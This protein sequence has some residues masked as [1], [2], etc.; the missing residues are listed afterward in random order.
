M[1][2]QIWEETVANKTASTQLASGVGCLLQIHPLDVTG[3]LFELKSDQVTIGRDSTCELAL[4]DSSVSRKHALIEKT[5]AGYQ[6]S[7]LGST[8]GTS[9]NE[10]RVESKALATGDRIQVGGF[11]FKFLSTDHIELQYHEAVYSMMTRDGLT[12]VL[13]KRS[14]IELLG[15]EY[16]QAAARGTQLSLVLFDIDHFKSVNDTHGHLAGDEV[17][18]EIAQRIESTI[19]DHN[20]FARYGGEEFAI[21][22]PDYSLEEAA[23]LAEDCRVVVEAL[24]FQTNAGDLPITVSIGAASVAALDSHVNELELVQAADVKLYEAKHG[25]RNRVCS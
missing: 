17:L 4:S 21:L 11:I 23:W 12:G 13:N 9:V 3:N 20:I 19:A 15:R 2:E 8:N 22:L 16:R 6:V 24:P 5:E 14:F 10:V 25:G 18:Q 1:T 7:D